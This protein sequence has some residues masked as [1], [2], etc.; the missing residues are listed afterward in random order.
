MASENE[1]LRDKIRNLGLA[2][3]TKIPDY[4]KDP[5]VIRRVGEIVGKAMTKEAKR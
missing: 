1:N 2:A 5:V 3:A 4:D